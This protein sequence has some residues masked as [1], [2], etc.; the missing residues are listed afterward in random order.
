MVSG[1]KRRI[2][3]GMNQTGYNMCTYGT[4]TAKPFTLS[5]TNKN[6]Q[7]NKK[8]GAC[9]ITLEFVILDVHT[10]WPSDSTSE[11]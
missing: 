11:N 10:L 7:K 4:V 5:Y 9:S 3:E 8:E 6:I 1:R 2:M